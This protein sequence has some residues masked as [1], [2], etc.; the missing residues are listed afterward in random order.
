MLTY[1]CCA[2]SHYTSCR[3]SS[4][5]QHYYLLDFL[6]SVA[7]K[8]RED[9]R[10]GNL[11]VDLL[12]LNVPTLFA[13]KG[14]EDEVVCSRFTLFLQSYILRHDLKHTILEM[15]SDILVRK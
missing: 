13:V 1:V 15:M 9:G 10:A 11:V 5:H 7:E 8:Y 6:Q 4:A 14:E 12:N 3:F 2:L